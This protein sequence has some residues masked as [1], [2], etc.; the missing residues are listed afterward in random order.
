MEE[1]NKELRPSVVTEKELT[2]I[3]YY[4]HI[5]DIPEKFRLKKLS[6]LE[7]LILDGPKK[8]EKFWPSQVEYFKGWDFKKPAIAAFLSPL[9]GIGKS[10]MAFCLY[11]KFI[12][13]F[14]E[15]HSSDNY[16]VYESINSGAENMDTQKTE[17]YK[18][19]TCCLPDTMIYEE[20]DWKEVNDYDVIKKYREFDILLI[21]DVFSTKNSDLA[22]RIIYGILNDR[23]EWRSLPTI[24]TSNLLLSDIEKID[25]RISSRINN[26]RIIEITENLKIKDYRPDEYENNN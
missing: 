6:D 26:E 9:N 2:D 17:Y 16:R 25:S 19:K 24:L 3:L 10:H 11:K 8:G 20:I 23:S 7:G 4:E 5:I 22:R 15:K 14:Y 1:P 12:Y 21:E 13:E 18:P